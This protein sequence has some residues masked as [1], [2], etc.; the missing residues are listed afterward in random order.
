MSAT[1]ETY[2]VALIDDRTLDRQGIE[3]VINSQPDLTVVSSVSG[4]AGAVE[5]A[6]ENCIDVALI[7]SEPR[8][9]DVFRGIDSLRGRFPE[10][11][12]VL[13]MSNVRDGLITRAQNAKLDG[14]VSKFD[15]IDTILTALRTALR[16]RK[17]YSR[18]VCARLGVNSV[19]QIDEGPNSSRP[20]K[21]TRRE[22][23]VLHYVVDGRTVKETAAALGMAPQTVDN[24]KSRMMKKLSVHTSVQ[25]TR[26]AIREGLIAP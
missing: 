17:Y 6:P 2:H 3:A 4:F 26:Y 20:P 25:L 9:C 23:D 1:R 16:K 10:I 5:V 24:H 13:L 19:A 12:I 8:Q 11:R 14:I 22:Y 15:P 21:L 7:D 18:P